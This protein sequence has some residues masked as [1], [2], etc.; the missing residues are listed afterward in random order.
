MK[1]EV[2]EVTKSEVGKG[3]SRG[4]PY[5]HHCLLVAAVSCGID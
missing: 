5:L 4:F 3:W 2:G 1:D